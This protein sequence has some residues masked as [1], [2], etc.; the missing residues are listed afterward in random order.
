MIIE[1][2]DPLLE[3]A[4]LTINGKVIEHDQFT[5]NIEDNTGFVEII[6]NNNT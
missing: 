4:T 2:N 5:W 3:E 1:I 6:T